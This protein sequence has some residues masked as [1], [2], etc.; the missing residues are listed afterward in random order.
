MLIW[1]HSTQQV[2]YYYYYYLC[3]LFRNVGS[4]SAFFTFSPVVVYKS[5]WV[6][7]TATRRYLTE[8]EHVQS[9]R[10]KP[11]FEGQFKDLFTYYSNWNYLTAFVTTI[12]CVNA[13]RW[14]ILVK[15]KRYRAVDILQ[16]FMKP[17][18]TTLSP[19]EV[20]TLFGNC[21]VRRIWFPFSNIRLFLNCVGLTQDNYNAWWY[22]RH[23]AD[24]GRCVSASCCH[25]LRLMSN[26]NVEEFRLLISWNTVSVWWYSQEF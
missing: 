25:T 3:L 10:Y 14:N 18:R 23:R 19:E 17:L 22:S 11:A 16:G 21:D 1:T 15:K 13:F 5:V 7:F 8:I 2:N 6:R 24:Y 9:R 26:K 4:Y 12:T 20:K